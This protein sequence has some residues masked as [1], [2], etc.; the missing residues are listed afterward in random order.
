[1]KIG[2]T[3]GSPVIFLRLFKDV[4]GK[5]V[6]VEQFTVYDA[7]TFDLV[8][9]TGGADVSPELYG[10][11]NYGDS[12]TNP[13][14]DRFETYLFRIITELEIPHMGICR[15]HQFLNAM[16]GGKL[17]QHLIVPHFS[18]HKIFFGESDDGIN[19]LTVNS[20]HHQAVKESSL[21]TLAVAGDGTIEMAAGKNV[22]TMQCHPESFM[23]FGIH[24]KLS[25]LIQEYLLEA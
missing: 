3:Y 6:S 12:H 22:L 17:F 10:E 21:K 18:T 11:R 2:I 16:Y 19:D 20:T 5:D 8:L 14:R 4:I 13:L 7:D 1:M 9:F 24:N 23:T 15:G 25:S